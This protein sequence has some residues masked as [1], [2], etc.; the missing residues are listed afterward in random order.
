M[1]RALFVTTAT[2]EP[3]QSVEAWVE[4]IGSADHVVYDVNGPPNDQGILDAAKSIR[5]D[6]FIYIGAESGAGVPSEDTFRLLRK[7]APSIQCQ[8]DAADPPWHKMLARYNAH[9]CFDLQ[10]GFDGVY[11]SPVD[12]V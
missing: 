3:R 5:P 7:I 1:T 4:S 8:G 2:S 6:V 9:D 12:H 11:D 10:V